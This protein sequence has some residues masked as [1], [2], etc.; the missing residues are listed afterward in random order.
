VNLGGD[1]LEVGEEVSHRSITTVAHN[2]AKSQAADGLSITMYYD[3]VTSPNT[4]HPCGKRQTP[5]M[6]FRPIAGQVGMDASSQ[7]HPQS[8]SFHWSGNYPRRAV[9]ESWRPARIHTRR[10]LAARCTESEDSCSVH[11]TIAIQFSRSDRVTCRA[12]FSNFHIT[13]H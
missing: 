13:N 6:A 5:A 7:S 3:V 12:S 10:S 2:G 1:E 9:H 8:R 4:C 11:Y